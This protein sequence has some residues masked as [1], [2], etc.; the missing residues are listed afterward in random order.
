MKYLVDSNVFFQAIRRRGDPKVKAW[1][2][3]LLPIQ[4]YLSPI[5]VAEYLAGVFKPP[6][7]E[8]R[9]AE[10]R[11]LRLA[12]AQHSY[13]G[14]D[15]R[16]SAR[17]GVLKGRLKQTVDNHDVWLAALALNNGLTVATRN[18]RHFRAIGVPVFN[19]F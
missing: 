13:V 2:A 8:A 3:Q 14:I 7:V 1:F 10:I 18:E 4:V 5:L 16:A 17:F 19:P 11:L 12:L 6:V 9:R 15:Y